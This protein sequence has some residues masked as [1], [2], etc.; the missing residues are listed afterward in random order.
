MVAKRKQQKKKEVKRFE[1]VARYIA[2]SIVLAV[3]LSVS[4]WKVYGLI[5]NPET[6]PVKVVRIDG[7]LK[8]LQ[9]SEIE[10]AIAKNVSGGFFEID[11]EKIKHSAS[12]IAW[13]DDVSVKRLWP[14]TLVMTVKEK[15]AVAQWGK[16][17][18]VTARGV[19][20][21]PT[22]KKPESLPLLN[23]PANRSLEIVEYF[24]NESSRFKK[25]KLIINEMLVD[26]R[27]SWMVRFEDGLKVELG[28]KD[29]KI[30]F[31]RLARYVKKITEIKGMPETIDLRYQNGMAVS[32]KNSTEDIE[33][34]KDKGAV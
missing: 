5:V 16:D 14:D 29:V 12:Q 31:N 18:L 7:D 32:W 21:E 11:L 24:I 1:K 33:V 23:G 25:Q 28:N 10:N 2:W 8:Y 22:T 20:F 26:E 3:V 6:L 17:K 30:K 15:V 4:S 34:T 19:I 9:V 13:V 27:G